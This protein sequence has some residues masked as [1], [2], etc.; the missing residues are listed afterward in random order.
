MTKTL[1]QLKRSL[2]KLVNQ[3]V[4]HRDKDLPCISCGKRANRYEAGHYIAQG[5]S[6]QLRYHLDNINSQCS[7]CNRWL[8]GNLIEYRLG[9]VQKLGEDKVKFLEEHRHDTKKWTRE[10]LETLTSTFKELLTNN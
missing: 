8:S 10:E 5:S 6:G 9:L 1:P 7:K 2:Q 3:Y 4:R